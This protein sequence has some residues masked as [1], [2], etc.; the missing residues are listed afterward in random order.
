MTA[1]SA[2]GS[3]PQLRI[4]TRPFSRSSHKVPVTQFH[5]S[6]IFTESSN[7][8][9]TFTSTTSYAGRDNGPTEQI[10]QDM[11]DSRIRGLTQE[12]L[13]TEFQQNKTVSLF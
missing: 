6:R 4:P 9:K 11:N 7:C 13:P 10:L 3:M 12:S 1:S 2:A 8:G 5:T